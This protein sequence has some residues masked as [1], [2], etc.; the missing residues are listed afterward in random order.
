MA[1]TRIEPLQMAE[2]DDRDRVLGEI[3]DSHAPPDA[4]LAALRREQ[5]AALRD[6]VILELRTKLSASTTEKS[7]R[8]FA[9]RRRRNRNAARVKV[10]LDRL[11]DGSPDFAGRDGHAE[12]GISQGWEAQAQTTAAVQLFNMIFRAKERFSEFARAAAKWKPNPSNAY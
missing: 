1:Q 5:W 11:Q 4:S 6:A 9:E 10:E 12:L 8:N 2:P 3:P 7:N